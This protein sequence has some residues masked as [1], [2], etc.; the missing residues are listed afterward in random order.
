MNPFWWEASTHATRPSAFHGARTNSRSPSATATT[1]TMT[2]ATITTTQTRT[3]SRE[4]KTTTVLCAVCFCRAEHCFFGPQTRLLQKINIFGLFKLQ[5]VRLR[6]CV[7]E[8]GSN[9]EVEHELWMCLAC[10]EAPGS[11]PHPESQRKAT[12]QHSQRGL[13]CG[14]MTETEITS[15]LFSVCSLSRFV[16]VCASGLK[17]GPIFQAAA[18]MCN[19]PRVRIRRHAQLFVGVD[20]C[21]GGP[22]EQKKQQFCKM[23]ISW[24]F[25]HFFGK[26]RRPDSAW[27][28]IYLTQNRNGVGKSKF[29]LIQTL[30]GRVWRARTDATKSKIQTARLDFGLWIWCGRAGA[31]S[32]GYVANEDAWPVWPPKFGL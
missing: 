27:H 8:K 15:F 3:I 20:C 23:C 6:Y 16:H 17:T 21:P 29:N 7:K 22:G 2:T 26:I 18:C 31:G 4:E 12:R 11:C 24:G 13:N 9:A 30:N 1:M 19:M 10:L 5:V 28:G 32:R 14:Y 25:G